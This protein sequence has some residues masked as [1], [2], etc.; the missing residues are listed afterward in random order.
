MKW[1]AT[2]L[3]LLTTTALAEI[4]ENPTPAPGQPLPMVTICSMIPPENV[5]TDQYNEIPFVEGDGG[6]FI[7][8]GQM[9]QGKLRMF[10]KPDGSSFTIM[11][12]IGELYCMIMTGGNVR[13]SVSGDP[14]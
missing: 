8:N 4:Q 6:I 12:Q 9:V 10:L 3:C 5:L 2:F 7:P 13:A 14:L 1:L 11:F